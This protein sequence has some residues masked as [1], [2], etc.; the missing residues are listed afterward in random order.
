M[1]IVECMI[2]LVLYKGRSWREASVER[3]K[4]KLDVNR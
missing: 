1:V 2:L 3:E 4:Q